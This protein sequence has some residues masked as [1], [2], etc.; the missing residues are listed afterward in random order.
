[1]IQATDKAPF[2]TLVEDCRCLFARLPCLT[3]ADK[4]ATK[5]KATVV[6]TTNPTTV[7]RAAEEKARLE[8]E[9]AAPK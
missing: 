6:V 1:M 8:K 3:A 7:D 5:E 9:K 2:A 4:A